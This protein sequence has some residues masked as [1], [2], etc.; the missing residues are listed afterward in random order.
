MILWSVGNEVGE[1]YTGEER[2]D[3]GEGTRDIAHDEDPTRPTTTAMNVAKPDSP[4]AAAVDV[5]SLNYQ[6]AGIR[7]TP[8][9]GQVSRIP[10][11]TSRTR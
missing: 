4:F 2:R 3:G 6:G 7:D 1:Q 5:I 10:R 9:R 8:I 11:R